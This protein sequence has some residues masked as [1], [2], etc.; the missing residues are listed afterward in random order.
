MSYFEIFT[1]V[2]RSLP[3]I[4]PSWGASDLKI[5]IKIL[6]SSIYNFRTFSKVLDPS[7]HALSE[8]RRHSPHVIVG[9]L[10]WPYI[11]SAWNTNERFNYIIAHHKIIDSLESIFSVHRDEKVILS[12]LDNIYPGMKIIL[13]RPSWFIREG[14]LTINIFINKFRSYSL[15]LSLAPSPGGD[16]IYCLIGSIQGRKTEN[17]ADLYREITKATYGLRP[18]DLLI[19]IC[20]ILCRKWNVKKIL[21]VKDAYRHHHHKYFRK[22]PNIS[23]YYDAIWKDRGGVVEN[24]HFYSLPLESI[25]KNE[26]EIKPK[27]RSLYRC[28]YQFLSELESSIVNASSLAEV[29]LFTAT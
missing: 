25:K 12:N 27:K 28:R 8:I 16:G 5:R 3:E 29:T 6:I 24:A 23:Q 1:L 11:C 21:G 14:G 22:T 18:R 2:G 7:S 19:E 26:S 20:R 10:V 4:A 13:D 17:A 9:P 15:T